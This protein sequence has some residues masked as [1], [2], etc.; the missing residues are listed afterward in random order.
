VWPPYCLGRCKNKRRSRIEKPRILK[1]V[2]SPAVDLATSPLPP[3]TLHYHSHR[4]V[5]WNEWSGKLVVRAERAIHYGLY[6]GWNIFFLSTWPDITFNQSLSGD[7]LVHHSTVY[8]HGHLTP[9]VSSPVAS[10]SLT[11]KWERICV[12]LCDNGIRI[13]GRNYD[14]VPNISSK[15]SVQDVLVYSN[16]F[17]QHDLK[18]LDCFVLYSVTRD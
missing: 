6:D 5:M 17:S 11:F 16:S 4:F 13:T 15:W 7:S 3:E 8:R 10:M 1:A 9:P 2:L 14:E 12:N 18:L